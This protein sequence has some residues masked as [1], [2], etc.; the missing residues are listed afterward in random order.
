MK[1]ICVFCETK[2]FINKPKGMCN[3]SKKIDLPL[4]SKPPLFIK[5]LLNRITNNFK[6]FF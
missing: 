4:F 3:S 5:E 6:K 2:K 1:N